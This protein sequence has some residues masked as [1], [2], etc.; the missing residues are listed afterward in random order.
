MMTP[1]AHP[2]SNN[3]QRAD[4]DDIINPATREE[5]ILSAQTITS[6]K[7]I[8]LPHRPKSNDSKRALNGVMCENKNASLDKLVYI[9]WILSRCRKFIREQTEDLICGIAFEVGLCEGGGILVPGDVD[10]NT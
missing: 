4:T 10:W 7:L 2:G 5:W 6:R 1:V 8:M 3:R 9:L